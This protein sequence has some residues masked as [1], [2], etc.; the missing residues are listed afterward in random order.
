VRIHRPLPPGKANYDWSI[1]G[2]DP[3][4]KDG[5]FDFARADNPFRGYSFIYVP[6]APASC[7]PATSTEST[8]PS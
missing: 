4:R 3:A 2:E 5:I 8:R 6:S 7:T 1:W